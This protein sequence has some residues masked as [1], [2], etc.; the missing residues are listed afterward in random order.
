[1]HL[2]DGYLIVIKCVCLILLLRL[3]LSDLRG[4]R[5]P[6]LLVL[7]VLLCYLAQAPWTTA[8]V[9]SHLGT[10]L[11]ALLAGMALTAAGAMGAGDAKL[12]AAVLCW[13]GPAA[14]LPVLLVVT[15]TGLLLVLLGVLARQA[16]RWRGSGPLAAG[17]RCLSVERGVP[18]GVALAAGGVFALWRVF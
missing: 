15:Q 8:V 2:A 7:G 18:Y 11:I 9:W 17:W 14:W 16:L 3:A 10:G 4:R 5:L 13:A 1:M 6:N 12:A